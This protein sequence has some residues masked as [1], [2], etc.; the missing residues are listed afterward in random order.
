M[1]KRIITLAVGGLL[2]LGIVV[3]LLIKADHTDRSI[4]EILRAH[5]VSLAPAAF[6]AEASRVM[7][8]PVDSENEAPHS[9]ERKVT[10]AFN[11][12]AFMLDQIDSRGLLKQID[13]LENGKIY[14]TEIEEGKRTK[15]AAQL[16][17]VDYQSARFRVMS[18]GII[19]ILKQLQEPSVA[20]VHREHAEGDQ[21]RLTVKTASDTWV[22][23]VGL[24]HLI[25]K[26]ER[27]RN[28]HNLAI[29]YFDYQTVG[30]AQ[31]PFS[32]RISVDGRLAYELSFTKIDLSP[33]FADDY[34]SREALAKVDIQ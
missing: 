2:V 12:S 29:E 8:R 11:G 23:Y 9:I 26:I 16:G 3:T 33:S 13:L 5:N 1:L 6:V 28:R 20:V 34:F 32:E 27:V 18:F 14:R 19:P 25:R 17:N 30:G 4:G 7:H 10:V 15:T 21:E 22:V 31:L 24:N